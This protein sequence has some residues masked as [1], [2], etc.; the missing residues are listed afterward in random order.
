[1]IIQE[2]ISSL[3]VDSI[4]TWTELESELKTHENYNTEQPGGE[5][6]DFFFQRKGMPL[7][8]MF[9]EEEYNGT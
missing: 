5:A 7:D 8:V 9:Q 2:T 3:D 1:M 6:P 4:L